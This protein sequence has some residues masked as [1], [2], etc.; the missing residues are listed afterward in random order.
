MQWENNNVYKPTY[1]YSVKFN[2]SKDNKYLAVSGVNKPL[3]SVFNMNTFKYE[4]GLKN[5]TGQLLFL[6]LMKVIVLASLLTLWELITI[7]NC[8]VVDVE[9][10]EQESITLILKLK[11][12]IF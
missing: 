5:I 9:M 3:F 11:S 7:R 8:F 10:E 2:K 1:I 12:F 6:V 4:Q